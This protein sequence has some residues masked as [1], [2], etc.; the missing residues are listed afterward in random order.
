MPEPSLIAPPNC[1]QPMNQA[2][3]KSEIATRIKSIHFGLEQ[4][5]RS[6]ERAR[7]MAML[8]HAEARERHR[9]HSMDND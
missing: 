8:D 6:R 5:I 7:T 4:R 2:S 1:I 3:T 9:D